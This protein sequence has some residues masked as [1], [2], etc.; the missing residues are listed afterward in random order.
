M[1]RALLGEDQR[2]LQGELRDRLC[3]D[4]L[5]GS[6]R[7]LQ[8]GGAGEQDRTGDG[9]IRQ[10]GVA[11][12]GD[13]AGEGEALVLGVFDYSAEQRVIGDRLADRGAMSPAPT[14]A[15]SQ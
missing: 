2:G 13:A 10:P 15:F 6:K 8:E 4:L 5:C 7:Q 1:H 14:E 9:V 11:G 3:A 12:Q